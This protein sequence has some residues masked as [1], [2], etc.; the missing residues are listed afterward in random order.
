MPIFEEILIFMNYLAHIFLSGEEEERI[1]GNFIGD[2]IKGQQW[3]NYP[4][5]MQEGILLHRHIDQF[6]DTHLQVRQSIERLRP[7][8]GRF[9]GI[10]TDVF[11]DYC[12]AQNFGLFSDTALPAFAQKSYQILETHQAI[13]PEKVQVIL[14]HMRKEDWLT[15]YA[16]IYGITKALQGLTKRLNNIV[17]LTKA[18]EVLENQ[19]PAFEQDFLN[20]FPQV[21]H[22]VNTWTMSK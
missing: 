12:L 10:V 22:T 6:T 16:T 14:P 13:L 20:F 2:F 18:I 11:Y 4:Q 1:V 9:A 8:V 21:Q 7:S 17:D 15:H 3:R 19:Y 5:K